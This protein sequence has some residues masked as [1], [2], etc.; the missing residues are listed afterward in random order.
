M[1]RVKTSAYKARLGKKLKQNRRVPV[2]VV[3]KTARRYSQ[4]KA[5]RSWRTQK[6]KLKKR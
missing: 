2:F 3:A 6:M 1:S 4:N 5:R